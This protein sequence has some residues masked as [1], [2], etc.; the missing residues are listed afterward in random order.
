MRDHDVCE[1]FS[2]AEGIDPT[3]QAKLGKYVSSLYKW[4]VNP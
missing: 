1:I 2:V 4:N 3:V